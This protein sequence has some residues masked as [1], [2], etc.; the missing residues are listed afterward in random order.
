MARLPSGHRV[1]AAPCKGVAA[2]DADSTHPATLQPAV[3]FDRLV[4]VVR[5]RRV[6]A[7]GGRQDPGKGH[8]ITA[9]QEKKEL[10]HGL[11]LESLSA[12][13]EASALT[14]ANDI[15]SI[16]GRAIRTT[17]YRIP[18]LLRGESGPRR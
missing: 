16:A 17:S 9:N 15:S 4:R 14:S 10:R 7:A 6:V 8:L 3:P 13:S 1:V 2:S 18:T 12:A 5:A 11:V